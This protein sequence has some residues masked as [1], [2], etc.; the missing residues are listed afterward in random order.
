M[1]PPTFKTLS[2]IS[3]KAPYGESYA[4]ACL[5]MVLSASVFEQKV[6][7]IFMDDGVYQLI[8]D[9]NPAPIECKSVVSVISTLELYGVENLYVETESLSKRGLTESDLAVKVTTVSSGEISSFIEQSDMVFN[10]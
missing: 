5:D 8:K 2:F 1:N 6:N 10:L 9:Q 7:Y 4:Q 3:R